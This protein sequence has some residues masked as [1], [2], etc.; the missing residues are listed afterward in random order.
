MS[1]SP[2][3]G[4]APIKEILDRLEIPHALIGGWAV[5]TWGFIRAS[6][7]FDLLIDLRPSLRKKLLS[8]LETSFNAEWRPAGEDDPVAGMIR[9]TPKDQ[10]I[11]PTDMLLASGSSD[12][13]ALRRALSIDFD[14]LS[15]LVAAP[16]DVIAMKLSAG[17]GQDYEDVKRLLD[18]AADGIDEKLLLECCRGRKVLDRLELLRRR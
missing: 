11:Y 1:P 2:L 6:E 14:G 3:H 4:L 13:E 18:V 7:D 12:R 9:A 17:G 15:L 8:E 16:E 10:T 5:I